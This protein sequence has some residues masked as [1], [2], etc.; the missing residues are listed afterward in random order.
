MQNSKNEM[1]RKMEQVKFEIDN[2][3]KYAESNW[4]CAF[5]N[6]VE[7]VY[8]TMYQGS[9]DMDF[10]YE[11]LRPE[12]DYSDVTRIGAVPAKNVR[13]TGVEPYDIHG[14]MARLQALLDRT[15]RS[16]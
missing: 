9:S 10:G 5:T 7:T 1:E 6:G 12:W 14:A 15:L 4:V 16:V 11:Q 13:L 2:E 8:A 3:S